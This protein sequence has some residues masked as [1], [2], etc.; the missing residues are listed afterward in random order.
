MLQL[1]C[2]RYL[3][4]VRPRST[5]YRDWA[6]V[7]DTNS[8]EIVEL[9][10]KTGLENR[11]PGATLVDLPRHVLLPGLINMHTHS[12][13]SLL[14]GYADDLALDN[15]LKNH[16]WPA[17][18][19]WA[20]GSFVADGTRLAL[21]EM[22]RSGTTC[23]NE[24]YFF[25]DRIAEEAAR[26]GCRAVVGIPVIGI[27][28]AW[29]DSVREYIDKGL[30]LAAQYE[31]NRLI[32]FSFAPHALYSVPGD[33]LQE[34]AELAVEKNLKIHLHLLEIAAELSM[35][36][37]QFGCTPIE[38][39]SRLGMLGPQLIAVHMVHLSDSDIES[40]A[41]AEAQ[42]VHCPHS[43]L[44]LASGIC[45][46]ADLV[47]HGVNVSI[48]SDG[49]ASNNTLSMFDEVRTAAL[50]AKGFS[51]EPETVD[52]MTALEMMT[53]NG[54]RALGMGEQIGSIEPHKQADLCAVDLS[55]ARTL[56]VHDVISHLAY[57]GPGSQVTDV[58]IAGSRVLAENQLTTLDESE[59]LHRAETWAHVMQR[60]GAL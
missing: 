18:Q 11:F 57:T 3:V 14:R 43:N 33:A 2:P 23:F 49:A 39:L 10:P 31:S 12:P 19:R 58:W 27:A 42:V 5:V 24:N 7:V 36:R 9:G 20:D 37:E 30:D 35:S 51:G 16:I 6:V 56:P 59:I 45:R 38:L 34:I 4:P 52:A 1:I 46:V 28:T 53:I 26:A 22:I 55:Q 29:A 50:L 60:G 48:G 44:K 21:V 15:W 32:Q 47:S 8:G 25:P 54:A 40:V 41:V 17:E 13:M